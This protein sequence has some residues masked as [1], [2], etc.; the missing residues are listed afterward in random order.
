MKLP[1]PNE[2]G[3]FD[4]PPAGTHLGVCYRLIDMGTHTT[5]FAGQSKTAR[6]VMLSWE[7]PDEMMDDGRP[8]AISKRYSFSM[9]EKATLRKD[10]ESW[11]GKAFVAEDFEGPNAFDMKRL[12]GVGAMLSVTHDTKEGRTYANVASVGKLMKGMT[13]P[14]LKNERCYIS[15]DPAEFD[16]AAYD[17]LSDGMKAK[18]AESP[19]FKALTAQPAPAAAEPVGLGELV[20]D[21]IPF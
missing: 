14:P 2:G 19:E 11:R 17:K 1:K 9:H 6:L 12:L 10:L 15:L 18:I 5:N 21:D 16:R 7:L 4:P 20:G 3:N 8:F 13:A